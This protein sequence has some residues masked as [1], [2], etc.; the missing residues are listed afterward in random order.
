M[1][2]FISMFMVMMLTVV[3]LVACSGEKERAKEQ[4]EKKVLK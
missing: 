4:Q 3:T 1:R 2:K